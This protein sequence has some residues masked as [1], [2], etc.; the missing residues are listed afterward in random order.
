MRTA[1]LL[2]P[3]AASNAAACSRM[4]PAEAPEQA[5][6]PD[7]ASAVVAER[8]PDAA[9]DL[10]S[11]ER[12]THV[13]SDH[14]CLSWCAGKDCASKA[15][16]F[17]ACAAPGEAKFLADNPEPELIYLPP[18]PD[19]PEDA[20]YDEIDP[21]SEERVYQWEDDFHVAKAAHWED[22]CL[23]RCTR[24]FGSDQDAAVEFC[25]EAPASVYSWKRFEAPEPPKSASKS[26]K[27]KKAQKQEKYALKGPSEAARA[28]AEQAGILAAM[29]AGLLGAWGGTY[30]SVDMKTLAEVE[31]ANEIRNLVTYRV[32]TDLMTKCVPNLAEEGEKFGFTVHFSADGEVER[33]A[34]E[35][36]GEAAE[37]L[38]ETLRQE[39]RLPYR[40]AAA[41]P[42]IGVE[43]NLQPQADMGS[44]FGGPLD[45]D[46]FEGNLWGDSIGDAYGV[47]GLGLT[48]SGE[49]G[50]G[51]AEGLG[52]MGTIGHGSGTGSGYGRGSAASSSTEAAPA[53]AQRQGRGGGGQATTPPQ[54]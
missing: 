25:Y 33:V 37:C 8:Q 6:A 19:A 12:C 49:G 9:C 35:R 46:A 2:A 31:R 21:E 47:G 29:G 20:A 22:G 23:D 16:D 44:M 54:P 1:C 13:C 17:Y 38:A 52:G 26:A 7:A 24:S 39:L 32:R 15:S 30:M 41:L 43:L 36:H 40:V 4:P 11:F 51:T 48:G 18:G 3:L 27:A 53:D 45:G 42:G 5:A 28:Q 34:S 10:D 14:A 50:G